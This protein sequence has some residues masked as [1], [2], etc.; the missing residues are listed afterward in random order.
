MRKNFLPFSLPSIGDEEIEE[1]TQTLR[2]DWITSGPKVERFEAEFARLVD[3]PA[4]LA[5]SSGTDA[6]HVAL[7]ALGIGPGDLV[8]T[9]SMT[10]CSTVHVIEQVGAT[11]LL[12]DVRPDTLNIDPE[13]VA[14]GFNET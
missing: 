6:M 7:T 12:V 8:I 4:A 11:P 3:A 13:K 2:S 1:V 9:T 14:D 10:F 5:V